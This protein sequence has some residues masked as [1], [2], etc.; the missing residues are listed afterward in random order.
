MR[1]ILILALLVIGFFV[2]ERGLKSI[3]LTV[4]KTFFPFE[5]T[6]MA[7]LLVFLAY[8]FFVMPFLLFI[9][10]AIGIVMLVGSLLTVFYVASGTDSK[11][12]SQSNTPQS[13]TPAVSVVGVSVSVVEKCPN[14]ERAGKRSIYRC[15]KCDGLCCWDN[16]ELLGAGGDGCMIRG[17]WYAV[18]SSNQDECPHCHAKSNHPISS[19]FQVVRVINKN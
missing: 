10:I 18:T 12:N 16:D 15:E 11:N 14:C 7:G 9:G 19:I 8:F 3:G 17:R 13:S 4:E 1:E 6:D 5:P 2:L